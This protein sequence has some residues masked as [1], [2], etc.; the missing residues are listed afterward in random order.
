M[1]IPV[2]WGKHSFEVSPGKIVPLNSLA[3]SV[4]LKT[5]NGNDTSGTAPTNTRG[6]EL[7]QIKLSTMYLRSAG[8]NPR[9]EFSGWEADLGNSYPLYVGG[10]RF[11]PE[12]MTL[13]G[14]DLSDV[15]LDSNGAF[16]QCSVAITLLEYSEGKTSKLSTSKSTKSSS[17]TKSSG[18]S[19]KAAAKY[20]ETI[21]QRKEAM[22]ATASSQDRQNKKTNRRGN[23]M[24]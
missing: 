17:S 21:A 20:N 13:T 24:R 5:D 19:N 2:I 8:T 23:I 18:A 16:L 15:L 11:G 12:R 3:T 14:V 6:R 9:A 4:T 1:G 22:N 10:E 7:Q